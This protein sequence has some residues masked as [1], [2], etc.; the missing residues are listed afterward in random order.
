MRKIIIAISLCASLALLWQ[1]VSSWHATTRL[2]ISSPSAVWS[3]SLSHF[4]DLKD[5]TGYTLKHAALGLSLATAASIGTMVFCMV[6]PRLLKMVLPVMIVVQV[7]PLITIAPLLIIILGSGSAPIVLMSALLAYFPIFIN[8][9]NGVRHVDQSILDFLTLNRASLWDKMRLAYFPLSLPQLF[10][11]LRVGAT[12][13]VIG[14]I[15]AEFS[16]VPIGLGRNLYV[17][18]LR[19]EPELMMV[20]LGLSALMGGLF[21]LICIGTERIFARWYSPGLGI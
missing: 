18:S 4:A 13:S 5:A 3:Y 8:F 11:G 20:T 21:Y 6:F 1:W 17:S 12:L 2:F 7:I 10:S 15:V 19:L 16:G 9:A 14:A